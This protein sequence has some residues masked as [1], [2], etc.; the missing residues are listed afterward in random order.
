MAGV[1]AVWTYGVRHGAE[2]L[3]EKRGERVRVFP[4]YSCLSF[5]IFIGRT[6]ESYLLDSS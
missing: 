1:A 3:G 5:V 2:S 6:F 4:D